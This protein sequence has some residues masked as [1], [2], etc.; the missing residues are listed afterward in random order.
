MP[1]VLSCSGGLSLCRSGS[2]DRVVGGGGQGVLRMG[3]FGGD[4]GEE[5]V[6]VGP[7]VE[8]ATQAAA[9]QE[10]RSSLAGWLGA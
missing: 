5:P 3:A 2:G 7:L 4:A 1:A 6:E 8:A 10:L 9:R